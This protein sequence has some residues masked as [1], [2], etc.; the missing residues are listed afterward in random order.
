MVDKELILSVLGLLFMMGSGIF[1][2]KLEGR[3]SGMK[4]KQKD[5][6]YEYFD[7][8]QDSE[9]EMVGAFGGTKKIQLRIKD[10]RLL[11]VYIKLYQTIK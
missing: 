10:P 3:S 7:E 8:F 4:S 6:R 2:F 1:V 11:E 5:I 9:P